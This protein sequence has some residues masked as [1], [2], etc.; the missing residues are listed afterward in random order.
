M[1]TPSPSAP[2]PEAPPDNPLTSKEGWRHFVDHEPVPPR[3]L[4]AAERAALSPR[5]RVRED[6]QRRE[7]HADLPM[8]HTPVIRKVTT[9]SRL[10]I[11]LNR[12]QISARRGVILSG[13]S[14]TGKTTALTQLGRAHEL[15]VRKRHPATATGSRSFTSPSHPRPRR[16]CSRWSSPASSA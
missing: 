9:T 10:L 11:Q 7:Y 5:E 2:D 6:E 14:G 12:N 3:P 4:T 16:R 8:V 15:A 1:N 13:A